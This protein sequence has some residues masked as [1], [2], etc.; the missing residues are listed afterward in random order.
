M[1]KMVSVLGSFDLL[2]I[3]SSHIQIVLAATGR[4]AEEEDGGGGEEGLAI[5]IFCS[6]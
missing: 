2:M 5:I 6:C 4:R 1:P 3:V